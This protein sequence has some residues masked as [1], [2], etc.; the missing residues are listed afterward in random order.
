ML[1]AGTIE[2]RVM[3]VV[4]ARIAEAEKAYQATCRQLEDQLHKDKLEAADELVSKVLWN[5][6]LS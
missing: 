4:R 5:E 1:F 2:R 6:K 3:K